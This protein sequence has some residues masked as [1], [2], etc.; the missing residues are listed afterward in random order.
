VEMPKVILGAGGST[1]MDD[2]R[3][4]VMV[5]RAL[6]DGGFRGVDTANHYRNHAGVARGIASAYRDG[7]VGDV[8]LQSKIEGCGN[9]VDRRSPVLGGSCRE[10]TLARL[11]DDLQALRVE[12]LDLALIHAPPCV[13]GAT[14]NQGCGGPDGPDPNDKV[15]PRLTDCSAEEACRM[16]QEQWKAL[17]EAYF[18]GKARAIGVSNYCAACLRCIEAIATVSPHVNQIQ[19]HAGMG[20]EDP[21]TIVSSTAAVGAVVQAYRPL[22]QSRLIDD[23]TVRAIAEANGKSPAQVALK[24]VLQGGHSAITTSENVEHMRDSLMV[25]GWSLSGEEM[26][27]L[28]AMQAPHGWLDSAVGE[29][30]VL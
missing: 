3:T 28:S 5:Y 10:D 17:E 13:P 30:C 21:S 9:S 12:R 27:R 23:P 1:W 11:D 25:Y 14:W 26:G 20:S 22:A 24:W 8:W 15:Y 29:M 18:A 2:D 6:K 19:L 4:D 16:V 7:Y